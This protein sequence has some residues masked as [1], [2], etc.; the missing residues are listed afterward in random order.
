MPSPQGYGWKKFEATWKPIWTLL[1]EAAKAS[2]KLV[3]CGCKAM[4]QC[5]RKCRSR[6]A[7]LSSI[8][9]CQCGG[10]CEH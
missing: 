5:L 1:P 9:L 7:G 6:G 8:A 3:K 2:R 10:N 4:P